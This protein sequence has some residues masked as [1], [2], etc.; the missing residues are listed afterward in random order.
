MSHDSEGATFYTRLDGPTESDP[1]QSL[2]DDIQVVSHLGHYILCGDFN[3]RTSSLSDCFESEIWKHANVENSMLHEV[4][5]P[6][7]RDNAGDLHSRANNF[8]KSLIEMCQVTETWILN[9][10][11]TGDIPG[12]HTCEA[13]GGNSVVDYFL[14]PPSVFTSLVRSLTVHDR[15]GLR[16][17]MSDHRALEVML[18]LPC[19]SVDQNAHA[20]PVKPAVK[21]RYDKDL[22]SQLLEN[23]N[24]PVVLN[25]L[26]LIAADATSAAAAVDLLRTAV[27]HAVDQTFKRIQQNPKRQTKQWYDQRCKLEKK[28]L[29]KILASTSTEAHFKSFAYKEY[30]KLLRAKKRWGNKLAGSQLVALAK[31]DS[32]K[33]WK[34]FTPKDVTSG[35]H[36]NVQRWY[37]DFKQLLNMP[38]GNSQALEQPNGS[39]KALLMH[40]NGHAPDCSLLNDDITAADVI[41]TCKLLKRNKAAD[42]HGMRAEYILDTVSMLAEYVANALDKVFKQGYPD[43][44]SIGV[45]HPIVKAGDPTDP[46]NYRGITVGDI[47][48]KLYATIL[49]Q[50]LSTW[51]EDVGVRAQGQ[52]GFRRA[53]RTTDNMFLLRSLVDQARGKGEKL[54]ACFVDFKKAFD[55][56]PRAQLWEHLHQL[57]IRG[58][59]LSALISMYRNV[60][61]CVQTP[62]EGLTPSFTCSLG[63]KQGCPLSPTLF[64]LYVDKLE[65]VLMCNIHKTHAPHLNGTRIPCLLYADDI[66]LLSRAPIG[67]QSSLDTLQTFCGSQGLT[68][69]MKKTQVLVFNDRSDLASYVTNELFYYMGTQLDKVEQYT[70]LGVVF[71]RKA[72]FKAAIDVLA[73]A[74][75]K[76]M[77]GMLRRCAAMGITDIKLKSELFD[78]L[79]SPVLSYGCEVWGTQYMITGCEVLEKVH[80]IFLRK[81]LGVRK[82]T[83]NFLL[84]AELGKLPLHFLWQKQI[85]KF[86]NR[87][88]ELSEAGS[89]RLLVAAFKPAW[90]QQGEH[91]WGR[92]LRNWTAT[93]Q[94][95]I[96]GSTT[97]EG[98]GYGNHGGGGCSSS[99]GGTDPETQF[100]HAHP[101]AHGHTPFGGGVSHVSAAASQSRGIPDPTLIP[102]EMD[103]EELME[104]AK[105]AYFRSNTVGASRK[106]H[107]FV[108]IH[109]GQWGTIAEYLTWNLSK[110]H[111]VELTR[112]RLGAHCLE[113][114]TGRWKG[115]NFHDRLCP[116]CKT[117]GNNHVEDEHHFIFDCPL[118][119]NIRETYQSCYTNIPRNLFSL[120]SSECGAMLAPLI[121]SCF[122]KRGDFLSSLQQSREPGLAP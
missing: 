21:H 2:T 72:D 59:F 83:A 29:A 93:T 38:T 26:K 71:H 28:R 91:T 30:R 24:Q 70:Y 64:G 103:V 118:Y 79:V 92:Q 1:F 85:M 58:T 115:T 17:H 63:V 14:A 27:M 49:D 94:E 45:I 10:R 50:R 114:E 33:F 109:G 42:V 22:Q 117:L 13:N 34:I 81:L 108:S 122:C 4:A 35:T 69:N 37:K 25:M 95:T 87:M 48:G 39:T 76:A 106:M 78:T 47:I 82:S 55:T 62:T 16:R 65:S 52:A 46:M 90:E 12:Q 20:Q 31:V 5:H 99:A 15:V 6:P 119:H 88:V 53:F 74:A 121:H 56:V 32:R 54:Y 96:S 60:Q 44:C 3:A 112:F 97:L 116:Y 11:T 67:L 73:V 19:N 18:N 51:A 68:V 57:G 41:K 100:E 98:G 9:G 61:A 104:A 110:K 105:L 107:R 80:K 102:E 111:K 120:F 7:P 101:H 84:Y 77:F 89:T 36:I 75:R 43:H 66:V 86:F 23:V 113:V 40:D 8:G